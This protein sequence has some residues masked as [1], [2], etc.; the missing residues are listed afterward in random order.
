MGE[1]VAPAER[2]TKGGS[3]A[4]GSLDRGV[5]WRSPGIA[6]AKSHPTM[7]PIVLFASTL[8]FCSSVGGQTEAYPN[9]LTWPEAQ[10]AFLQDGPGLLLGAEERDGLLAMSEADREAWIRDFLERDPIP[11][12]EVNELQEGIRRRLQLVRAEFLSLIDDRA[13]LLFLLGHQDAQ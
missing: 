2:T 8:L 12:T 13:R 9:P 3:A 6:L 11:E 10:R 1:P 7:K 4:N 5:S